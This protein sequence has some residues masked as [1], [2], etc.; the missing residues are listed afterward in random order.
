MTTDIMLLFCFRMIGTFLV[1]A[2][3]HGIHA[4]YYVFAVVAFMMILA[5]Y[6]L[7]KCVTSLYND[8]VVP[9][10][11][12]CLRHFFHWRGFEFAAVPFM[13]LRFDL[14]FIVWKRLS[15][16]GFIY[17]ASILLFSKIA[18]SFSKKTP[19][20]TVEPILKEKVQ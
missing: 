6:H 1:S 15:F 18:G 16:S 2:Y 19:P 10:W 5:E 20:S 11:V 8:T 3:W 12:N 7:E 9:I 4:G 17:M 13:F 14:T